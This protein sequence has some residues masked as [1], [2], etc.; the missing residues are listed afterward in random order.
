MFVSLLVLVFLVFG[1]VDAGVRMSFLLCA[2]VDDDVT[3]LIVHVA[4]VGVVAVGVSLVLVMVSLTF[5]LMLA[6]MVAVLSRSVMSC[7]CR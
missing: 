2:I 6:L 4:G 1:A 7:F 5:V 3:L